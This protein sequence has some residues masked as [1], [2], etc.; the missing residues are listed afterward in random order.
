[1]INYF[2]KYKK[3]N[4]EIL[5]AIKDEGE[6]IEE[7]LEEKEKQ[8]NSI[9]ELDISKEQQKKMYYELGLD[10]LDN[11]VIKEFEMK[12]KEIKTEMFKLNQMNKATESYINVTRRGNIFSKLL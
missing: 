5:K 11:L 4:E 6:N 12:L 7:L 8:V 2:D 1:M 3:I 10:K 9:I